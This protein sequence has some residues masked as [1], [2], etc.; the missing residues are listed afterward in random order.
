MNV[1]YIVAA[2]TLGCFGVLITAL[3]WSEHKRAQLQNQQDRVEQET[4]HTEFQA[5]QQK[6]DEEIDEADKKR[7]GYIDDLN[8]LKH[9][10]WGG[11]ND[12]YRRSREWRPG[13][14]FPGGL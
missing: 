10:Q 5:N 1:E 6:L 11:F 3:L 4:A 7:R 2:L 12:S 9:A 14:R 13:D 8:T